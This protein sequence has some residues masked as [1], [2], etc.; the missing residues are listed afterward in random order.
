[1]INWA[2]ERLTD[3]FTGWLIGWIVDDQLIDW[4]I[5][6][7]VGWIDGWLID[8]LVGWLINLSYNTI[9]LVRWV[10]SINRWIRLMGWLWKQM[11]NQ[12]QSS[13]RRLIITNAI[14]CDK[15]LTTR[16]II[17]SLESIYALIGAF[18]QNLLVWNSFWS[19]T[20][21]Y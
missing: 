10:W 20:T 3:W 2:I 19:A 8:W 16:T 6:S 11:I 4:F 14:R 5:D 12:L 15:D 1:M 7:I 17:I 18:K 21:A 9:E 13:S